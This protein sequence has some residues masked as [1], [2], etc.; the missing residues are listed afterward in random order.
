[1]QRYGQIIGV[2]AETLEG[3]KKY[4]A[5]VWPEILAKI[6]ECNIKNYS[7]K[8]HDYKTIGASY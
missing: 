1:M 4:H 6:A 8:K 5:A 7:I 2:K 3:Y